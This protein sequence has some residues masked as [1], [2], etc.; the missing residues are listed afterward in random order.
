MATSKTKTVFVAKEPYWSGASGEDVFIRMGDRLS[1]DHPSVRANPE[2]FDEV[3]V[4]GAPVEQA[5]RAP[6]EQRA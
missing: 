3:E 5:T 2:M 6:G 4:M 1:A